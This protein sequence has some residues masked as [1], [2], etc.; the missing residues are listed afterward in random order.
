MCIGL[1]A[2][3]TGRTA[4]I[5]LISV[6]GALTLYVLSTASVLRL[7]TTA[8]DLPRPYKTPLYPLTPIVALVLSLGALVAMAWE[9][10]KLAAI[11][12][13]IVVGAW[14]AF[15]IFVPADR[16]TTFEHAPT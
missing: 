6:F 11:Y 2:L 4:D 9:H 15:V 1:F 8:P 3:F 13:A 7:R 12:A 5:I 10:P 16:R 14:V